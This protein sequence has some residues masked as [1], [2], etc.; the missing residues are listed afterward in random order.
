M[1]RRGFL[2]TAAVA[3]TALGT[4][5]LAE[6][7]GG[8]VAATRLASSEASELAARL[9]RGMQR[10]HDQ[11]VGSMIPPRSGV[12]TDL[13]EN[14]LRLTLESLVVLDVL[15]SLPE[16]ADVPAELAEVL[17][18]ALPRL[19]R[20]VHTHHALLSRMPRDR[21]RVL[22]DAIRQ[23]PALVMDVAEWVDH[24]AAE[25]GVPHENRLRLRHSA[26]SVGS[27]IRRQSTNAVV[28]DCVAKLDEVFARQGVQLPAELRERTARVVDVM[29]RQVDGSSEL[30]APAGAASP[31][32]V[33]EGPVMAA[34]PER[35]GDPLV[36]PDR[37]GASEG[38]A[39][40]TEPVQWNDSWAR[41]GDEEIRLGAIMMPLG[42][43][44]CGILLFV[45]L[46]VL[47]AGEVQ[48]GDWD[49]VTHADDAT[50]Q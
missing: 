38:M 21:R 30:A 28:D 29:W 25:L 16:G 4:G 44:T 34:T 46:G 11:P 10:L 15:R 32:P 49:G 23:R 24:H 14:V 2:G 5:T 40:P 19:D 31:A 41:P 27:R 39:D 42:L 12:R 48:N 17:G 45:G 36:V 50:M 9:S 7:C 20:A 26:M 3:A 8:G 13:T 47:I 43:V 22:D 1:R 35:S 37:F 33:T 6:G 18:P